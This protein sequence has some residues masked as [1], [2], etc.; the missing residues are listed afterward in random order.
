MIGMIAALAMPAG[1]S[2]APPITGHVQLIESIQTVDP[3]DTTGFD[4]FV[5]AVQ[6]FDR[7]TGG[8]VQSELVRHQTPT[9]RFGAQIETIDFVNEQPIRAL[10]WSRTEASDYLL[11]AMIEHDENALTLFEPPLLLLPAMLTPGAP[12]L[13]ESSMRVVRA[14]DPRRMRER[15]TGRQSITYV[16]RRLIETPHERTETHYFEVEFRADL[17]L[18]DVVE[19]TLI[20]G[21]MSGALV[22]EES[23]QSISILGLPADDHS[24][25]LIRQATATAE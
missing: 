7:H 5:P 15:G 23:S 20:H 17:R 8:T 4:L 9:D 22:V 3:L 24:V 21:T 11:H 16:G 14:D 10:Y 19:T 25:L 18:A 12:V 6:S 13:A 2:S 1:C